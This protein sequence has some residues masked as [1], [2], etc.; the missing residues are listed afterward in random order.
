VDPSSLWESEDAVLLLREWIVTLASTLAM[1][2]FFFAE[3]T[4]AERLR[5]APTIWL[6]LFRL[7]SIPMRRDA[8]R[9]QG[10]ASAQGVRDYDTPLPPPT[11]PPWRRR[12][13]S[14]PS[15]PAEPPGLTCRVCLDEPSTVALRP[16]GHVVCR[17]CAER[18]LHCPM[19]RSIILQ[20]MQLYF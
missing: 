14:P 3:A 2:T 7:L 9:M 20:R 10:F 18:L 4:G 5:L 1:L 12:V 19:C 13:T 16:C 11:T 17:T 8:E 6:D 15:Q